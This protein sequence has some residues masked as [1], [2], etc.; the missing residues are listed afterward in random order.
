MVNDRFG[1]A[2]KAHEVIFRLIR[3]F[4]IR[5][6]LPLTPEPVVLVL[7]VTNRPSQL[8]HICASYNSQVYPKKELLVVTNG[9]DFDEDELN[10]LAEQADFSW[11]KTPASLTL[12][13]ALNQGIAATSGDVVAKFDDDDFYGP[14]YLRDAVNALV[15]TQAGVV[16]KK[17]YFVYLEEVD[18]TVLVYPGN[19]GQRVGRVAGGTIVANRE[20]FAAVQFPFLNLGEDVA[21]V[22]SAERAG[23]GVFSTAAPGFLQWRGQSGHTWSFDIQEFLDNSDDVGSGHDTHLWT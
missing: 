18:R 1:L 13:A 2:A 11:L 5:K 3:R 16:G 10:R 12:G 17:T 22:R 8:Q 6:P 4:R 20:V 7:A 21:F 23:F 15:E 19:E 14:E 9:G